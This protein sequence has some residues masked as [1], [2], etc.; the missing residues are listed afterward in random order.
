M[1][2]VSA[3]ARA[4]V[5]FLEGRRDRFSARLEPELTEP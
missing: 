5:R 1:Q 3:I 2:K 4:G